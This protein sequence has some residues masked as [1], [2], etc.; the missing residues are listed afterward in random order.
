MS[1]NPHGDRSLLPFGPPNQR[2]ISANAM[3][4]FDFIAGF[5]ARQRVRRVK[6]QLER[7]AT[8]GDDV[9]L[10][11]QCRF[12]V[13]SVAERPVAIGNH[14]W[15]D[16]TIIVRGQGRL[17]IGSYCSFRSGTYIGVK[18]SV[19]IGDH[20]YGAEQVYICDNNNHPTSPRAR[21]EMTMSP[22]GTP[23]WKWHLPEV[24]SAPIRI[25]DCV[26]LGRHA[27][28]LKGVEIGRGSI[29]AAGAVVTKSA[30]PFSVVAG[31]PARVVKTLENDLDD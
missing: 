29:V 7:C 20:V 11:G 8:I 10:T 31:N 3:D 28:I 1:L 25:E 2:K 4:V 18:C 16:G 23:P 14:V 15:L 22:P 26:W 30:P 5:R 17:K 12:D 9:R 24:A 21:R 6:G 27:M 13:S 19:E